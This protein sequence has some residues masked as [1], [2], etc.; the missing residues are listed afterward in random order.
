M[1]DKKKKKKQKG[2]H[3]QTNLVGLV[4][5]VHSALALG[6]GNDLAVVFHND[7]AGFEAAVAPDAVAAVRRLEHLNAD[8]VLVTPE[9]ALRQVGKRAIGAVRPAN[10]AVC[11]VALV[12]HAAVLAAVSAAIL[13]IANAL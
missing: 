12:Q 5:F 11:V 4:F 7:L 1:D 3:T 10:V 13:G 6:L 9:P 8:P 2:S